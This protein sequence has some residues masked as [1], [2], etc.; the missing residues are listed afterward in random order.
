MTTTTYPQKAN[1][2]GSKWR[3]DPISEGQINF[4][5]SLAEQLGWGTE[6]ILNLTKGQASDYISEAKTLIAQKAQAPQ[7]EAVEITPA[8]A[9]G[10]YTVV[11]DGAHRTFRVRQQAADKSFA[12]GK[13]IISLL[14]GSDNTSSYTGIGFVSE[15]GVNLWK[16]YA[17][18]QMEFWL[19]P[20]LSDQVVAG[21]AYA[22]ESG[23]CFRCNRL[24]TDPESIEYGIGPVC[25]QN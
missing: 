6:N 12:P 17:E 13:F 22:L 20:L 18:S 2:G 19:E 16:K 4:L 14:T 15:T 25:R 8:I 24:L 23:N 9:Q 10:F 21:Q 3:N 1:F 7:P 11:R 5:T